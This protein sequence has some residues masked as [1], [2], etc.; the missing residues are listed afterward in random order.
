MSVNGLH[1]FLRIVHSIIRDNKPDLVAFA[2]E[3][4]GES[5]RRKIE[6]LYKANRQ[7]APEDL[8]A[9]LEILPQLMYLMGFPKFEYAGY[10]ADD[11]I[12]TLVKKALEQGIEPVVVSSDKDFCQ[13]I[14]GPVKM[15]NVSKAEMVDEAGVFARYGITSEQFQ[16]Y[17]SIVGDTSDNIAG[18]K[19]IGP[20]GAA[21]LLSQ[22]GTLDNIYQNLGS[23]KG[24]NNK[25]LTESREQVYKAKTLISF[26]DV[27][28][29]AD[30]RSVCNW[31]GVTKLLTKGELKEW[32]RKYEFRE[33]ENMFF[34]VEV[35][36][37]G[38][39][40]IGVRK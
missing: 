40:E 3:G 37:V 38:G 24:A 35:V 26:Y 12:S 4:K 21:S 34:G 11:T 36:N 32:L 15:Y 19:G 8:K 6:P 5:L 25:K 14:R 18:V 17:L 10:E 16:D 1:G 29:V 22:W 7:E 20:K 39:L 30:L 2:M 31:P 13:L 28:L 33:I 27:P 9:Q 23:I